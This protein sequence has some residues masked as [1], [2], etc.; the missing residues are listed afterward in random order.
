META[1]ERHDRV[2]V[3]ISYVVL[4]SVVLLLAVLFIEWVSWWAF[5]LTGRAWMPVGSGVAL[6]A[7]AALGLRAIRLLSRFGLCANT[8]VHD[9]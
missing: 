1:S 6:V 3:E 4:S 8:Q 9:G 2:I 5:S 7:V